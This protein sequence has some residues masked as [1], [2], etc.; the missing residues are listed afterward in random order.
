[1]DGGSFSREKVSHGVQSWCSLPTLQPIPLNHSLAVGLIPI[2][3]GGGRAC[4]RVGSRV[5]PG[6]LSCN[7]GN[8]TVPGCG[9]KAKSPPLP[10]PQVPFHE[11][12]E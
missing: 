2:L 4:M 10:E 9:T 12:W 7:S 8:Q 6:V 3:L 5:Q 11:M 1:M